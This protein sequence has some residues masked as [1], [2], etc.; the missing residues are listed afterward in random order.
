MTVA[1]RIVAGQA[2]G[3]HYWYTLFAMQHAWDRRLGFW[4]LAEEYPDQPA[5]VACPSG[6]DADFRGA[7]GSGP[8][9]RARVAGTGTRCRRHRRLRA[10]ERRR[11]ALLAIGGAGGRVRLHR[12]ESGALGRRGPADCGS[13]GSGGRGPA[14]RLRGAGGPTVGDRIDRAPRLG[15]R[16]HRRV[17]ERTGAGRRPAHDRAGGPG[18]GPPHQLLVGHDGAAQSGDPAALAHRRP[19]GGRRWRQDVRARLPIPAA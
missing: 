17:H 18:A 14:P 19:V 5:V 10:A 9:T 13:L 8:P 3:R 4:Y 2:I 1:G 11:H 16:R 7:G 12:P 15:R 6:R